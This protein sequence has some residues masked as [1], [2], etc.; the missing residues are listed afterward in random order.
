M[1]FPL[2]LAGAKRSGGVAA[3]PVRLP[4]TA[5]SNVPR[6]SIPAQDDLA[7]FTG[8]RGGEALLEIHVR[9]PV[10]D[11]RIEIESRLEHGR[12]LVPG[13]ENLAAVNALDRQ[14][15]EDDRV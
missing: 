8:D 1:D 3:M 10:G 5:L 12:H 13:L 6:G 15:V 2:A 9:Q 11:E 7:G 4:A 14:H